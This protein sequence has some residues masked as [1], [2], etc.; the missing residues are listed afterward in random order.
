MIQELREYSQS[1]F[2][3]LLLGIICVTFVISFGIGSFGDRREVIAKVNGREILLKDYQKAYQEGIQSLRQQ[4]GE[5]ADAFAEQINLRQRVFEQLIERELMAREAAEMDLETTD[6]ELQEQIRRQPY[7]HK[8]G[9]FDYETYNTVLSQNRIVRH[10]YEDSLRH[11]LMAGKL[12]ELLTQG[13]IVGSAEVEEIFRLENEKLEISYLH[14]KPEAFMPQ[15]A[16]TA[17]EV[18]SHF[19]ENKESYKS[20]PEFR[21]DYFTLDLEQYKD[22]VKVREREIRRYYERNLET[23]TTPAKVKAR[24][25][26]LKVET[27]G[28]EEKLEQ[29]RDELKSILARIRDG[30]DFEEEARLHSEDATAE[31]GGDLGWFQPGEM[32]PAF[33]DAAFRLET[34]KVSEVVQS[35]FGIHLIRVDERTEEVAKSLEEVREEITGIL[36]DKRA[37][38]KLDEELSRLELELP[39]QSLE[40]HAVALGLTI[41]N[42]DSFSKTGVIPGNGSAFGLIPQL[43]GKEVEA[44]GIWKRNPVQGH[45]IY[46]LQEIRDPETREFD[47]VKLEVKQDLKQERA[48]ELAKETARKGME[49]TTAGASLQE[50]AEEHGLEVQNFEFT[51]STKFLPQIGQN[52]TFREKAL[53][54]TESEPFGLHEGEKRSD[55][56]Q[57]LGKRFEEENT[58]PVKEQIRQRLLQRLTQSVLVKE[59]KRLRDEAEVE[60]II[61]VF[62]PPQSAS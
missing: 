45:L 31:K 21:I 3:K 19:E 58:E 42:S 18:R 9:R 52:E 47:E 54:L 51:A 11:D 16:M 55:L 25:I 30:A 23:Y 41:K 38:K 26:L 10:E 24:H 1:F 48:L 35:P 60:I 56:I 13:L 2:F 33:E 17:E 61:P 50:L 57:L 32:V 22:S 59:L 6:L 7:F 12:Q 62:Q 44:K 27:E 5:N 46:R 14:F 49:K 34:G 53:S 15:V 36:T 20:D 29:R 39:D 43:E 28:G 40:E 8:E 37:E 4:F